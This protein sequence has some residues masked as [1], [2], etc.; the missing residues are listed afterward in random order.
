M[1][2]RKHFFSKRVVMHGHRMP[3][4]VVGSPS[5]RV[6]RKRGDVALRD[7]VGGHGGGGLEL[8]LT[9]E[10]FTILKDSVVCT[11]L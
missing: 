1:D 8:G 11:S 7:T 10:V 4:E 2:I 3:R 9:L 5:L 6:F